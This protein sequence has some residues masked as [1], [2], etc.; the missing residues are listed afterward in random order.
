MFPAALFA[1]KISLSESKVNF[2]DRCNFKSNIPPQDG[3]REASGG[4]VVFVAGMCERLTDH[5]AVRRKGHFESG[6]VRRGGGKWPA[7]EEGRLDVARPP[8]QRRRSH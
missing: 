5:L 3:Q 7:V 1:T 4:S 8:Q 2:A 6:A